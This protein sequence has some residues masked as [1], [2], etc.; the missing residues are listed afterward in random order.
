[1]ALATVRVF[2][3]KRYHDGQESVNDTDQIGE[4]RLR[5]KKRQIKEAGRKMGETPGTGP[6]RHWDRPGKPVPGRKMRSSPGRR[7]GYSILFHAILD[8]VHCKTLVPGEIEGF[9]VPDGLPDRIVQVIVTKVADLIFPYMEYSPT[10]MKYLDFTL[11]YIALE[12][13][14]TATPRMF[15]SMTSF[16]SI[17]FRLSSRIA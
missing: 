5:R 1:L 12:K 10:W 8:Q 6:A 16:Y 14:H 2:S 13:L 9:F 4:N 7:Y 15:L 17:Q 3:P 11:A